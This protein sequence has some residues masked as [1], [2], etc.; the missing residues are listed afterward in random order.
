MSNS[1]EN[2]LGSIPRFT[3][4][5]SSRGVMTVGR[6]EEGQSLTLDENVK[7]ARR[8]DP[9]AVA[10]CL[11]W[12]LDC[13]SGDYPTEIRRE[14]KELTEFVVS[15]VVRLREGR[16][17]TGSLG[18]KAVWGRP[19]QTRDKWRRDIGLSG[20]VGERVSKGESQRRAISAVAE[21]RRLSYSTVRRAYE[22]YYDKFERERL[23]SLGAAKTKT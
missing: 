10:D 19:A 1:S 4:F 12:W 22:G 14:T 6:P 13:K 21:V 18:I 17:A 23:R 15:I 9:H 20:A 8:G 3:V 2:P 5:G 16:S 11:D 7:L